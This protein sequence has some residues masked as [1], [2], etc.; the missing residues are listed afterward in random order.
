M[1]REVF[2]KQLI[3]ENGFTIKNF[4]RHIDIPYST[5]LTMLNEEKLGLTSVDNAIR[6]CR[7][8]N[9]TIQD[10]QAVE[11]DIFPSHIKPVLTEHEEQLILSYRR[12]RD[13]QKAVDTLLLSEKMQ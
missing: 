12:K 13:L 6:I 4:A 7:G 3:K 8:L 10:L 11:E 5:L 9:I 1:K 2:L